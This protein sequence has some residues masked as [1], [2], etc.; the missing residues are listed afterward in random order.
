[1]ITELGDG[2]SILILT[3]PEMD[4]QT[5]A[6]WYSIYKNLP[7]AKIGIMN[8]RNKKMPFA[9]YQWTK[10]L[11]IRMNT[12]NQDFRREDLPEKLKDVC[13]DINLL[14]EAG[15]AH[16]NYLITDTVLFVRPFFMAVD[17]LNQKILKRLNES[18]V[19]KD[20]YV[21]FMKGQNYGNMVDD[22]FLKD[23]RQEITSEPLCVDAKQAKESACLVSYKK[24]CGRWI[25]TAKGCPFSSA[26]GLISEEMTANEFRIIDLWQKMVP[27]YNVVM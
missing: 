8:E 13:E 24:G 2:L 12:V 23:W 27:L 9:F 19:I 3:E 17:V 25:D 16:T 20:E 21:W 22:Y 15:I 1:M 26:G 18:T 6:T 10:R 7:H 5:F 14:L 11:N 4:W